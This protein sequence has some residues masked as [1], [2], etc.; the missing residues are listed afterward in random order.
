MLPRIGTGK[1]DA[2]KKRKEA[3]KDGIFANGLGTS[4][5]PV[6]RT[7]LVACSERNLTRDEEI[8]RGEVDDKGG[9]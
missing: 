8:R 7:A 2:G 9:A 3:R 4:R 1:V 6:E 5:I